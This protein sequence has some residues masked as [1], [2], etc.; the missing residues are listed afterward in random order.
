MLVC[1][2]LSIGNDRSMGHGM[3]Q[4]IWPI[5]FT[6]QKVRKTAVFGMRD[7]AQQYDGI[8]HNH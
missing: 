8:N 5:L 6:H 7:L 3:G 4:Q 2:A 1:D